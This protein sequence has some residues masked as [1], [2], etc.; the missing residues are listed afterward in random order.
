MEL[1]PDELRR[2]LP[3]IR[4]IHSDEWQYMIYAKLFTYSGVA[5]YVAEGEQRDEDYLLWG[6]LIAPQFKFPSRFQIPLSRLESSNWLGKEPCK[7]DEHFKPAR[8][9]AVERTIPNLRQPL[10]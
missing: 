10:E 2:Q 9:E 1:L 5:F 6:L 7:R 4:K 3:P 8:W